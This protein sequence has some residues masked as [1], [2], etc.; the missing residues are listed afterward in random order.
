MTFVT[1]RTLRLRSA[2]LARS[3][4]ISYCGSPASRL[5]SMSVMPGTFAINAATRLAGIKRLEVKAAHLN[6]QTFIAT[7]KP[8]QQKLPLRC[9]RPDLH[10]SNLARQSMTQV[11]GDLDIGAFALA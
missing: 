1:S 5:I 2:T 6:R 9:T 3:T 11:L 7:Q 4:R 10:A 8:G